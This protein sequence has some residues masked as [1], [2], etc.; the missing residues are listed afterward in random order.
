MNS[1]N[2]APLSELLPKL[3]AAAEI[4]DASFRQDYAHIPAEQRDAVH[5]SETAYK[6]FYGRAKEAYLAVSAE[7]GKLLYLLAR[8]SRARTVIEFGTSFGLSTLYLAAALRDNGGGRVI[9][10][11]LEPSKAAKARENFRAAG[12]A[13]LIEVREGDALATLATDL[14]EQVDLL[15]LDGAKALYPKVL[16]AIEPRLREGSIVLADNADMAPKFLERVRGA[17]APYV[18]LPFGDDV[19]VSMFTGRTSPSR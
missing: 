5:A 13:E 8:T 19:E 10:A 16:D 17:N 15:L 9:S 3:F 7:T 6:S 2:S 4:A 1:L 18:S 12:L 14:P 11:E